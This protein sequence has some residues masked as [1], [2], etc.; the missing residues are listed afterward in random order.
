[1]AD[2]A[3]AAGLSR[4]T[5]YLHFLDPVPTATEAVDTA[6]RSAT[7]QYSSTLTGYVDG[8]PTPPG[9]DLITVAVSP[10]SHSS[11]FAQETVTAG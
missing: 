6:E 7:A 2:V 9:S 1:M 3:Q 4:Q 8:W 11:G 10:G 5:V